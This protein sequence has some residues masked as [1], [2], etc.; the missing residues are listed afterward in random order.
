MAKKIIDMSQLENSK[1]KNLYDTNITD[2]YEN[3]YEFNRW[4][5]SPR[6]R[7]DFFM[8]YCAIKEH[9]KNIDYSNCLELGPGPGT[10]TTVLYKQNNKASYTLVDISEAMKNQYHLEMRNMDNI[11]YVI[12]DIMTMD[13]SKK[14]DFF[15][16]SRAVEYLQNKKDFFTKLFDLMS[17]QSQGVIITKNKNFGLFKFKAD[18]RFQ[19]QGQ[20][21]VS[22]CRLYLEEAG[23][24]SIEFYPV[25]IRLPIF[26]RFNQFF[27]S[28]IFL[29]HISRK[30]SNSFVNKLSESYLVKFKK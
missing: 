16:S 7:C 26:D 29:N 13:F 19:H 20:M 27:S 12:A 3:D 14:F 2:R 18:S 4:F 8:N 1:V 28:K 9:V 24:K 23:F 30:L 22:E 10:W 17:E 15:F 5:Q 25:I 6:L 11:E 21:T